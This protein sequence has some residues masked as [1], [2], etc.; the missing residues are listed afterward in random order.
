MSSAINTLETV[1]PHCSQINRLSWPPTLPMT[2]V[3]PRCGRC[4]QPLLPGFAISADAALF[5][6]FLTREQLPLLVDF[7]AEW[8][9][10]CRSLAPSL[11]RLAA[12]L[13]TLRLLKV[14]SDH[15]QAL[16]QQWS[17]RGIPTLILLKNS[18]ELARI[19]GALPY[20]QLEAWVK[21]HL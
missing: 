7:W 8:C 15:E 13:P 6:R 11:A 12:A 1:C 9:G 17:I 5:K 3:M 4:Q 18:Q 2:E 16:A 21:K 14:N 10:P 20:P 19:S